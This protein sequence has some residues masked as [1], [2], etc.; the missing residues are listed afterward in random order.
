M[1]QV[2][3]H[4]RASKLFAGGSRPDSDVWRV[5]AADGRGRGVFRMGH[6]HAR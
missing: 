6:Y 3:N 2:L 5:F 4:L 1:L